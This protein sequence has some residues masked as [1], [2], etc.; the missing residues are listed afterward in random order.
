MSGNVTKGGASYCASLTREQFCFYEMRTT[1]KLMSQGLSDAE[2]VQEIV[3]GNL[4]QY[5][6]E[7]SIKRTALMC[8]TRLRALGDDALITA[9]ASR[10]VDTAKQICLYAMMK[11]SLLLREFM[12]T[13]IAEKYRTQDFTFS[14][15]DVHAFFTRLQEQ[16][17][18]VAGWSANTATRIQ[19]ILIRVLVENDYLDDRKSEKLNPVLISPLLESAMRANGDAALLP[20]FYCFG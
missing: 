20:A 12:V 11:N 2:V 4:F 3:E 9:V 17:D 7:K 13:V 6:T 1:A 5:P 16:N 19:Q 18:T 15:R 8:A 14:R 10:P